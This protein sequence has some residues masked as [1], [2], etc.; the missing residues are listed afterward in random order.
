M[1]RDRLI[2]LLPSA[3]HVTRK[4]GQKL[5]WQGQQLLSFHGRRLVQEPVQ[6]LLLWRDWW[7]WAPELLQQRESRLEMLQWQQGLYFQPQFVLDSPT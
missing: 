3:Q 2:D 4:V 7:W 1:L 5:R 6:P